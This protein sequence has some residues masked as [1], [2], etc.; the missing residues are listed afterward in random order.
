M[1]KRQLHPAEIEHIAAAAHEVN[2]RYCALM[3]DHSHKPW[4]EAP[5][6]QKE[7]SRAGVV[8]IAMHDNTPEQSH[9]SWMQHKLASGWK[10]GPT[11]DEHAKTHPC[12]V[13]YGDLP[14]EQRY[15]DTLYVQTVKSMVDGLWRFP[16]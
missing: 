7:S 15:K 16:Q 5:D 2:R 10:Y 4:D 11:K 14:E 13:A 9:E 6:W 3:G 1:P 12:M 8:G